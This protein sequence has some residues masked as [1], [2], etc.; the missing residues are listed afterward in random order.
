MGEKI[1]R[2]TS[3]T[4]L[5]LNYNQGRFL[6][7]AMKSV[8]EQSQKPDQL[9]FIDDGSNIDIHE[10]NLFIE[11]YSVSFSHV[12][13]DG[14]NRG[15]TYRMNQALGLVTSRYLLLLSADDWLEPQALVSLLSANTEN[16]A[17]VF[18]NLNVCT[19]D[20]ATVK[21][22]RPRETWQG[23]T[24][25]KYLRG[26]NPFEDILKVNNFISGGMSLIS[27]E[28]LRE[29]NGWDENVTTEDLD[30]WLR[31]GRTK[32]FKYIDQVIGNYRKV[33]GSKSRSDTSK[34]LD[35]SMIF[36]KHVGS[37]FATD[38]RLAYLASMRWALTVARSG[39]LPDVSLHRMGKDIGVHPSYLYLVLPWAAIRPIVGSIGNV[40]RVLRRQYLKI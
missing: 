23:K 26:S 31:M 37:G 6:D 29:F 1:E 8:L 25:R 13:N 30:L 7:E 38:V 39:R 4:I 10:L 9:L 3:V 16:D 24:A 12:I 22:I 27:V 36:S 5:I 34:L 18:G 2:D 40:S 17:V 14:Q 32:T 19:E 33:E 20:G 15:H 28:A 35:H 11:K 21:Y